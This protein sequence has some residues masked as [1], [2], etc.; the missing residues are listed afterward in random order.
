MSKYKY[1]VKND[2]IDHVNIYSKGKTEL[3]R[4]L[5]NFY[6]RRFEC[7]DGIFMSIEGYW[8]W[9]L[10]NNPDKDKL[11]ELY[12]WKAK[13]VGR[14]LKCK[15]WPQEKDTVFYGKILNA[16]I[17]KSESL[18]VR[19]FITMPKTKKLPFTHYYVYNGFQVYPKNCEWLIDFWEQKRK[20]LVEK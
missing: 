3:G 20:E 18:L 13:E 12:G 14:L 7:E 11:K 17:I 16:L 2:G 6:K 10:C 8:Y 9:L 1:E 5:S 19:A 15:D 4:I